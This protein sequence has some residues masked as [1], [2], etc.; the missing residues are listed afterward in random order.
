MSETNLFSIGHSNYEEVE[1]FTDL[2]VNYD[3]SV[4]VDVRSVP[5][6]RYTPHFNKRNLAGG[7]AAKGIH[8]VFLGAELGGKPPEVAADRGSWYLRRAGSSGF[9]D[10]L[11]RLLSLAQLA[12]TA[13][14]CSEADPSKCHRYWLINWHLYKRGIPVLHILSNELALKTE[15]IPTFEEV[16]ALWSQQ[17]LF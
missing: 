4:L 16:R 5:Y 3:I 15:D 10:G 2:L 8:Y 13:M 14:M 17:V 11:E 12:R 1:E 9:R 6:S 7:L